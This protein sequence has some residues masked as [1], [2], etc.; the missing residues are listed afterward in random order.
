MRHV[1][2]V[3]DRRSIVAQ[4]GYIGLQ[5]ILAHLQTKLPPARGKVCHYTQ[6]VS[7][8]SPQVSYSITNYSWYTPF[9][10]SEIIL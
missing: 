3:F 6:V 4:E 1:R 8:M 9:S 10:D 2:F 7:V 5:Q